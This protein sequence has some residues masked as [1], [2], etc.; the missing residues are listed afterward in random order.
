MSLRIELNIPFFVVNFVRF[1]MASAESSFLSTNLFSG[2]DRYCCTKGAA[3]TGA[4]ISASLAEIGASISGSAISS[5][6]LSNSCMIECSNGRADST[7]SS[8]CFNVNFSLKE[9][10]V[11]SSSSAI[12][13]GWK[14]SLIAS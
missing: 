3:L 14:V 1:N 6:G 4:G 13:E 8:M 10:L 7:L 2:S 5:S 11:A 12:A 9:F